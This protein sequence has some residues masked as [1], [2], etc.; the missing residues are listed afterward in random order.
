M[1]KFNKLFILIIIFR[2]KTP[3]KERIND[4]F[5]KRFPKINE[6]NINKMQFLNVVKR[7]FGKIGKIIA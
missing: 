2:H 3:K 4:K 6:K 7:M 1:L 5:I